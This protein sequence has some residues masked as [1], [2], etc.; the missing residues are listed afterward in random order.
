ME[1]PIHF[2]LHQEDLRQEDLHQDAIHFTLHTLRMNP[3]QA[4]WNRKRRMKTWNERVVRNVR[5]TGPALEQDFD[6]ENLY[7][8]EFNY[9]RIV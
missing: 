3:R 6:E 9:T 7:E 1:Y 5:L 4:I 8:F 2:I